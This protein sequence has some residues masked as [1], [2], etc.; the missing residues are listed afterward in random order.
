MA[1]SGNSHDTV[2][3]IGDGAVLIRVSRRGLLASPYPTAEHMRAEAL[4]L[5]WT[6]PQPYPYPGLLRSSINQL[7]AVPIC[8]AG[9]NVQYSV[10]H[11]HYH[12]C[13]THPFQSSA[14]THA[15]V[16]VIAYG[17][18]CLLWLAAL[19]DRVF[20]MHCAAQRTSLISKSPHI[21]SNPGA[22]PGRRNPCF[23][24]KSYGPLWRRLA[25]Q[26]TSFLLVATQPTGLAAYFDYQLPKIYTLIH[27]NEALPIL[28]TGPVGHGPVSPG[29]RTGN[30]LEMT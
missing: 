28:F 11:S 4:S 30:G 2:E 29:F 18:A 6:T 15:H 8:K 9:Q 23:F 19:V 14:S 3:R 16:I 5:S 10:Y 7:T 24:V 12:I 20:C 25:W 27:R 1:S 17:R 21:S 22:D 13:M 26:S